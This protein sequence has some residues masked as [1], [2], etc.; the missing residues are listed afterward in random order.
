MIDGERQVRQVSLIGMVRLGAEHGG[1]G[2]YYRAGLAAD[3]LAARVGT[4]PGRT[5]DVLALCSPR[6]HVRQSVTL[7]TRYLADGDT[8]GMIPSTAAALHHYDRTGEIRGPKT[9]AFARALRGD[10]MAVVVDVW[11]LRALG[12]ERPPSTPAQ[13]RRIADR[14]RSLTYRLRAIT[15]RASGLHAHARVQASLWVGYQVQAG[16]TPAEMGSEL[17]SA[18]DRKEPTDGTPSIAR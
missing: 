2:W 4:D 11:I 1:V 17:R 15:T 3:A 14:V 8:R 16:R 7:A 5:R 6:V 13:Y 9:S 10:P 12:V 18:L